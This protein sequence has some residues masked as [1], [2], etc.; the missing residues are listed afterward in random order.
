MEPTFLQKSAL[1]R[2]LPDDVLA[3]FAAPLRPVNYPAGEL[4]FQDGGP[5]VGL[6]V[7]LD[8]L[9]QY[10]KLSGRGDRRRILKILGPG[11]VFGEE[12]LFDSTVCAC[13][14]YARALTDASV[15]FVEKHT[16]HDLME[17]HP[18][19]A[20]HLIEWLTAQLRVFECKLVE[21]AY[22][23]LE[24]N[25]LRLLL[26]LSKRFGVPERAGLRI[27][28]KLN[29]QGLA[30]LL[31]VHMDTVTRELSKLQRQGLITSEDHMLVI[32]DPERLA[33]RATPET[34]CLTENIF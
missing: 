3:E 2:G 25:L 21:L 4:V 6:Y 26:I 9:V 24:Q 14:G 17:R 22:E 29:H 16:F 5:S 13:T 34:T 12:G 28:F 1:F 32:V 18:I 15:A 19:V 11:D 8:G 30:D 7:I 10:G 31:G 23:T 33:K 27:N 20:Q